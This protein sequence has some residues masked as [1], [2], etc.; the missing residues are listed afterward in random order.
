MKRDSN[1]ALKLFKAHLDCN[2]LGRISATL[3]TRTFLDFFVG[4]AGNKGYPLLYSSKMK[5]DLQEQR[6]RVQCEGVWC[7]WPLASHLLPPQ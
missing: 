3:L 7:R 1:L 2:P 4:G 5:I 6:H